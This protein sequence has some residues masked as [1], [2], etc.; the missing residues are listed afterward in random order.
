M[1]DTGMVELGTGTVN[2]LYIS[3][4]SGEKGGSEERKRMQESSEKPKFSFGRIGAVERDWECPE[5]LLRILLSAELTLSES[6]IVRCSVFMLLSTFHKQ[7]KKFP[8]YK[9][10]RLLHRME[11]NI[12]SVELGATWINTG[13]QANTWARK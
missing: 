13:T 5:T 4:G 6:S 3:D 8:S 1:Q 2:L 11:V 9:K 7:K 10:R 12:K